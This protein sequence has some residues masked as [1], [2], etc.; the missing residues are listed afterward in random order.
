[1]GVCV[2]VRVLTIGPSREGGRDGGRKGQG[3]ERGRKKGRKGKDVGKEERENHSFS[4]S[5]VLYLRESSQ[6]I[7]R[8]LQVSHGN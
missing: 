1:M 8:F 3:M 2:H 4:L 5:L 6:E 7:G